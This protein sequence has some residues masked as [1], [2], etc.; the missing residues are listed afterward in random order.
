MHLEHGDADTVGM[1]DLAQEAGVS[2]RTLYR[3]F[4]TRAAL[5]Q[6]A[7]DWVRSEVL[8]LD[9]G[10][11]PDGIAASFRAGTHSMAARPKLAHALLRTESGRALRGNYRTARIDA[12]RREVRARAPDVGRRETER[13]AAVLAYLCSLNAWASL[14]EESGLSP[15]RAED[16]LLWAIDIIQTELQ[17]ENRKRMPK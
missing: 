14:Q 16:A 2:R 5:M 15:E 17:R 3:Y 8:K 6:A 9:P 7:G 12:I 13:A 1:E 11:G 4:P 10:I